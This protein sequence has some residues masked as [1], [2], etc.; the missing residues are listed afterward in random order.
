MT[1]APSVKW[2]RNASQHLIGHEPPAR[3]FIVGD[4][5]NRLSHEAGSPLELPLTAPVSTGEFGLV[6]TT[7]HRGLIRTTSPRHL[8]SSLQPYVGKDRS[9]LIVLPPSFGGTGDGGQY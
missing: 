5:P 6:P 1:V 9:L 2:G 8:Q 3:G 7:R 4:K